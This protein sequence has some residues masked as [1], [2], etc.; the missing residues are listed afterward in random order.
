MVWGRWRILL[1]TVAVVSLLGAPAHVCAA[2][3][4][5]GSADVLFISVLGNKELDTVARVNP[6]GKISFPLVGDVQ[7]AGMTAEELADYLTRRLTKKIRNPVV[8]VSLRE[9]NSY[10]IYVLGSVGRPGVLAS[11]SEVTVLQALALA[12]GI[13]PGT[14]LTLAY[15]ARGSER[16]DLD[17]RKLLME[18]DLSQNILLK[19]E[20]VVVVPANPRNAV[21][22]MGEVKNPG[23]FPLDRE[24]QFTIL[25]AVARAGGFSDF[26]KPSRTIII[27]EEGN[28]KQIIPADVDEIIENPQ[29]AKDILLQPG[30][31]VIVPQGGLF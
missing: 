1:A 25:K 8:S 11:K 4:V 10:R 13:A 3:Y 28:R 18:G 30:D 17:F 16:L 24:S 21:F 9:V 22:V 26:A 31:V 12:G 27:R 23:T 7:A 6:G 2:D 29:E 14:D 20:D 15:V 5:I 19:P